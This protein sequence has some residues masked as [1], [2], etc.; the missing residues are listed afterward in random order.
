MAA[1]TSTSKAGT[2]R[3]SADERRSAVVRAAVAEFALGGYHG[4]ST[5]AIAKR[6]GVSQPYLF[7]LYA[8]K[9]ALFLATVEYAFHRVSETFERASEGRTGFAAMHAMAHAYT[10]FLD[11]TPDLLRIQLQAFVAAHDP[12]LRAEIRTLWDRL[13]EQ[14]RTLTG[15]GMGEMTDFFARGMLCNVIAALDLPR[16]RYFGGTLAE[17]GAKLDCEICAANDADATT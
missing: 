17:D 11:E 1:P 5:A 15:G 8:D 2:V 13:D 14:V 16:E 7:R 12:Q 10:E 6:V 3:M 4:T 9:Q